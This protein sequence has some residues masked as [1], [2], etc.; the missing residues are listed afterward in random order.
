MSKKTAI[1]SLVKQ[2]SQAK[3]DHMLETVMGIAYERGY[4][5]GL[6]A[7]LEMSKDLRINGYVRVGDGE[8]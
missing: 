3:C 1:D 7:A 8:S 4:N 2:Y 5:A 6:V